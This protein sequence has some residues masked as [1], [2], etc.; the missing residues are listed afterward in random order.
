M[1]ASYETRIIVD[2]PSQ[3]EVQLFTRS[4]QTTRRLANLKPEWNDATQCYELFFFD[5]AKQ[6]SSKN[7]ILIDKEEEAK[8]KKAEF[9]L[10][11]GKERRHEYN[12][13]FMRP[14]NAFT[15]FCVSL[16][17]SIRKNYS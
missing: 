12:L 9:V 6:A 2:K 4:G 1:E 7:F 8:Q 10:L 15:A 3:F 16:V 17:A 14:F 11:H 13:H 5:Q